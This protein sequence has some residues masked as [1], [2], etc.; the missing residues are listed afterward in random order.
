MELW[1]K[2]YIAWE[3]SVEVDWDCDH[4]TGSA[5]SSWWPEELETEKGAQ[6]KQGKCQGQVLELFG[7]ET[8]Q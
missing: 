3:V 6:G 5:V 2:G 1:K 8:H 4:W 7:V